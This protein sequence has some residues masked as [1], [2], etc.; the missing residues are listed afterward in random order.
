MRKE[1]QRFI[2]AFLL[3]L[4]G[5]LAAEPDAEPPSLEMLE[6]LGEWEENEGE[7]IDPLTAYET[8]SEALQPVEPIPQETRP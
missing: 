5:P 3:L 4:P 2:P 1:L 8:E 6:Y 7:L